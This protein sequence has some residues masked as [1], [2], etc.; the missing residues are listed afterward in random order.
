MKGNAI[1]AEN[2][3]TLD[4]S[5][6]TIQLL[7]QCAPKT[8]QNRGKNCLKIRDLKFLPSC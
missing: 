6:Q 8:A 5:A 2:K 7:L 3:L 1:P 4:R